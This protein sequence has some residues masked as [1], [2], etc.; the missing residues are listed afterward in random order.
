MIATAALIGILVYVTE[1]SQ[2]YAAPD[3]MIFETRSIFDEQFGNAAAT[4]CVPADW[5]IGGKV[6]WNFQSNAIPAHVNFTVKS[7]RGDAWFNYGGPSTISCYFSEAPNSEDIARQS[8]RYL[9]SPV[10][11]EE[12]IIMSLQNDETVS[13]LNVMKVDKLDDYAAAR[14]EIRREAIA[15]LGEAENMTDYQFDEAIVSV[16]FTWDRV[17]WKAVIYSSVNYFYGNGAYGQ[18]CEWYTGPAIRFLAHAGEFDNYAG[19]LASIANGSR[20][21]PVWTEAV[22]LLCD[23]ELAMEAQA[24]YSQAKSRSLELERQSETYIRTMQ[25]WIKAIGDTDTWS[26]D[27][28]DYSAPAGYGYAWSDGNGNAVYTNDSTFDPNYS[29]NYQGYWTQMRQARRRR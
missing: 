19:V 26:D 6:F 11:P 24:A 16:T 2:E 27:S 14:E 5:T 18:Y 4:V 7:P 1:E 22:K 9:A 23:Q 13:N 15:R 28:R 8:G 25:G 3:T 17:L 12:L 29:S 21:D 10:S 20:A